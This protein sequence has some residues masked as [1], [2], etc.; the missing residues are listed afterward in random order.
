M[1]WKAVKKL[2]L[3]ICSTGSPMYGEKALRTCNMGMDDSCNV[4]YT[5]IRGKTIAYLS[6]KTC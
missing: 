5:L 1:M 4:A 6:I 3:K 2:R